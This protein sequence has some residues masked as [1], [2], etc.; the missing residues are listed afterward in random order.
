MEYMNQSQHGFQ[1]WVTDALHNRL[2]KLSE[3]VQNAPEG[4]RNNTLNKMTGVIAGYATGESAHAPP[5]FELDCKE[6]LQAAGVA[7][8]LDEDETKS[9]I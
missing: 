4:Q 8:G 6:T 7:S 1:H 2:A 5:R 9:A 3:N